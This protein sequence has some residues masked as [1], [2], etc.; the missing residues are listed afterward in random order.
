MGVLLYA[1]TAFRE[2][3]V[4]DLKEYLRDRGLPVRL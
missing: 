2:Y 3:T 1:P 4:R